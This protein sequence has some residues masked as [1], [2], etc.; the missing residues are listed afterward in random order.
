MTLIEVRFW[1]PSSRFS[2]RLYGVF[3]PA[4]VLAV[5]ATM[6]GLS[7]SGPAPGQGAPSTPEPVVMKP[8]ALRVVSAEFQGTN[9][10]S[11]V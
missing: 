11:T 1:S 8:M 5:P 2:V 4:V 7:G 9:S 3:M 6:R 10:E